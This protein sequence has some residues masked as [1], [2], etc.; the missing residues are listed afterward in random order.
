[1]SLPESPYEYIVRVS[2]EELIRQRKAKSRIR[3]TAKKSFGVWAQNMLGKVS[4]A[5]GYNITLQKTRFYKIWHWIF[6]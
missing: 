2:K 3:S 4:R 1:M 6:D 5:Y